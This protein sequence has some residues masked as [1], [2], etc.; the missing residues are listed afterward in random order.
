MSLEPHPANY[1]YDALEAA[2]CAACQCGWRAYHEAE[3]AASKDAIWH[4]SRGGAAA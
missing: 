2:W 1:W 3:D 4:R